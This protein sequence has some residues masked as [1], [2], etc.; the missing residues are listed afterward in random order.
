LALANLIQQGDDAGFKDFVLDG[1]DEELRG[2]KN[3]DVL[4]AE[5]AASSRILSLARRAASPKERLSL[6]RLAFATANLAPQR[7][8]TE[9]VFLEHANEFAQVIG[10][11]HRESLREVAIQS[12]ESLRRSGRALTPAIASSLEPWIETWPAAEASRMRAILAGTAPEPPEKIGALQTQMARLS[13]LYPMA[14]KGL[15]IDAVVTPT[16]A[17]QIFE[18]LWS[19]SIDFATAVARVN[20]L[21][22]TSREKAQAQQEL[23]K[24][25]KIRFAV[26][27][28]ETQ[29]QMQT[30]LTQATGLSSATILERSMTEGGRITVVWEGIR[31]QF[32]SLRLLHERSLREAQASTVESERAIQ[33]FYS[34]L[35]QNIT[36]MSTYPH[37]IL[38]A[39]SMAVHQ[40]NIRILTFTGVVNIDAAQIMR[41]LIRGETS[42]W[43]AYSKDAVSLNAAQVMTVF[44][45]MFRTGLMEAAGVRIADLFELFLTQTVA[46][47]ALRI[48]EYQKNL[49]ERTNAN[50]EYRAAIETC[51]QIRSTGADSRWP[52]PQRSLLTVLKYAFAGLPDRKTP[53]ATNQDLREYVR[54][55][56]R[57]SHEMMYQMTQVALGESRAGGFDTREMI[58]SLRMDYEPRLRTI[59]ILRDLAVSQTRDV[60]GEEA[61]NRLAQEIDERLSPYRALQ[62]DYRRH[63]R[64]TLGEAIPCLLTLLDAEK[65]AQNRV[66]MSLGSHLRQVHERMAAIRRAGAE[67]GEL[68]QD[69][70]L[71]PRYPSIQGLREH[72]ASMG[73]NGASYRLSAVQAA[74]LVKEWLE[75]STLQP[76]GISLP[77]RLR[78]LDERVGGTDRSDLREQVVDVPFAENVEDFVNEG[79]RLIYRRSHLNGGLLGHFSRLKLSIYSSG[80][81]ESM[82]TAVKAGGEEPVL[83]AS[84]AVRAIEGLFQH[85]TLDSTGQDLARRTG[86]LHRVSVRG[87]LFDW[88]LDSRSGRQIGLTDKA[89]EMLQSDILGY[90][91]N[92]NDGQESRR[93][94]MNMRVGNLESVRTFFLQIR[95]RDHLIFS[96]VESGQELMASR[97]EGLLGAE[98]AAQLDFLEAANEAAARSS[99]AWLWSLREPPLERIYLSPV[100]KRR[101]VSG[102]TDYLRDLQRPLPEAVRARFDRVVSG[103]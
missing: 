34:A 46:G 36:L 52:S 11:N 75:A 40:L 97:F 88:V 50:P 81:I 13:R 18:S 66:T 60:A 43:F 6:V 63:W 85:I 59:E 19:G 30:Y 14:F 93:R 21:V 103:R 42:P 2:C 55:T 28:L 65:T 90:K 7:L 3:T 87:D 102:V 77:G 94:Q 38:I 92:E 23:L 15:G 29:A 58:E 56:N 12:A 53:M 45:Y 62:R 79:L 100:A 44:G 72:E 95:S 47:E 33:Q 96:G 22:K 54:H 91:P 86:W 25:L 84:E 67:A 32:E 39:H 16:P 26:S 48:R 27:L 69:F 1:C 80:I 31:G 61:A 70:A 17:L 68:R 83:T 8:E 64:K 101:F 78:E 9:E 35:G 57:D 99:G 41:W 82:V 24:Y 74:L 49:L 89:F 20:R 71:S 51:R 10:A 4:R 98:V 37:M 73:F 5:P 76:G